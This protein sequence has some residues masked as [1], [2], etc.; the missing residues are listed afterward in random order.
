MRTAPAD[1]GVGLL[2]WWFVLWTTAVV[3]AHDGQLEFARIERVDGAT[4]TVSL[5][6]QK[7]N[8]TASA[9]NVQAEGGPTHG[10]DSGVRLRWQEYPTGSLPER[11]EWVFDL[12]SNFR[13]MAWNWR[14]PSLPG[15]PKDV[16]K[17]LKEHSRERSRR[18][19]DR[20]LANNLF[21]DTR[22]SEMREDGSLPATYVLISSGR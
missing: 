22:F 21:R 6:Q 11:I 14:I 18:Y 3:V 7:G 12:L 15:P 8:G 17:L 20:S 4:R 2:T 5:A 19:Q 16:Q 9:A 1:Y 13:G 10:E